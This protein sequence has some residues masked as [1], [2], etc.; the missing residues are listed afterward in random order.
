[1]NDILCRILQLQ[2]KVYTMNCIEFAGEAN[3]LLSHGQ[4]TDQDQGRSNQQN[5]KDTD[6]AVEGR[7]GIVGDEMVTDSIA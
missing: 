5:G 7:G 3:H 1:M 6:L 4:T 2:Q